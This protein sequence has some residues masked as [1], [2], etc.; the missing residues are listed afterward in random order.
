MF[1]AA[2]KIF[3]LKKSARYRHSRRLSDDRLRLE[4][5]FSLLSNGSRRHAENVIRQVARQRDGCQGDE[6]LLLPEVGNYQRRDQRADGNGEGVGR[7]I[8]GDVAAAK[9]E[10]GAAHAAGGA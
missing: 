6:R 4:L 8:A 7:D 3:P 2:S 5:T 1:F 9:G 10:H